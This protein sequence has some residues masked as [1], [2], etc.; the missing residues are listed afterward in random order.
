LCRMR[1]PAQRNL[2]KIEIISIRQRNPSTAQFSSNLQGTYV[3]AP[4]PLV[5]HTGATSFQ[6][7][8]SSSEL[9]AEN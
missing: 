2:Q 5:Q 1:S 3:Q 6:L 8:V 7:D 4:F 9:R